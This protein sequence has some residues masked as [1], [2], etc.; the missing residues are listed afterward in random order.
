MSA[1]PRRLPRTLLTYGRFDLFHQ[2]HIG[3][4]RKLSTLG[5]E[6]IVG[7]TTDALAE[8]S[9]CPCD[10]PFAAR[11]AVLENCRFVSRVIAENDPAQ[12]RTDIV[13]YNVSTLAMGAEHRGALDDLSDIAQVLYVPRTSSRP[14]LRYVQNSGVRLAVG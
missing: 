6:L 3:F 14:T 7:C 12:K 13:N 2:E 4:L 9:G 11:R 10:M 1:A 5:T 8:A